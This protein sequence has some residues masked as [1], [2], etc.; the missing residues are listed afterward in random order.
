MFKK[1]TRSVLL[2]A[3]I[4]G[5]CMILDPQGTLPAPVFWGAMA[6]A[7]ISPLIFS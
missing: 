5:A 1:L 3:V 4:V 2:M 6:T 7:G